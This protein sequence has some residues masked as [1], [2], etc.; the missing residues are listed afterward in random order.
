MSRLTAKK[1]CC[2]VVYFDDKK[3]EPMGWALSVCVWFDLCGK[4]VVEK[5]RGEVYQQYAKIRRIDKNA[6]FEAACPSDRV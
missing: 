1:G 5:Q 6:V 3:T 2:V 4:Y